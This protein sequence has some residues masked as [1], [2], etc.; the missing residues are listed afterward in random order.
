MDLSEEYLKK[1]LT[2]SIKGSMELLGTRFEEKNPDRPKAIT[3]VRDEEHSPWDGISYISDIH[4]D[5]KIG[6]LFKD[7]IRYDKVEEY[8]MDIASFLMLSN[9]FK[10]ILIA[11]DTSYNFLVN[12]MFY[13]ALSQ[14]RKDEKIIVVLGNHELWGVGI[15]VP[16]GLDRREY[17]V[18]EYRK[19]CK[20]YGLILLENDVL[21]LGKQFKRILTE[22]EFLAISDDEIR[23]LMSKAGHVILGG[24][25]FAGK[26][27][28]NNA[29]TGLYGNTLEDSEKEI[30][31]SKRFLTLYDKL[32]AYSGRIPITA[33]S[34]MPT[35]DWCEGI[36]D[37][38]IIHVN[39]HTHHNKRIV[40]DSLTLYA[41]NQI[42]YA[43]N[44]IY[45]KYYFTT[46]ISEPF[47]FAEDGIY[48]ITNRQYSIFCDT[49]PSAT[50]CER[51][52][53]II[54]LK[55]NGYYMFMNRSSIGL[56]ILDG[57]NLVGL[58]NKDPEYYYERMME[59]VEAVDEVYSKIREKL[60]AIAEAVRS[61]GGEG[62]V[63]G[64]IVDISYYSHLYYNVLDGTITPY[65]A[66][67]IVN[68]TVYQ[69]VSSLLYYEEKSIYNKMM[70]A[71]QSGTELPAIYTGGQIVSKGVEYKGTEM[72]RLS[73][74]IRCY[75]H[76]KEEKVIRTWDDR[77][78]PDKK[79]IGNP[80]RES[81]ENI[82]SLGKNESEA[83]QREIIR[84][85][86]E[87]TM[88]FIKS[89]QD[90]MSEFGI[91]KDMDRRLRPKDYR[92]KIP[93]MMSKL[94]LTKKMRLNSDM[95]TEIIR[96]VVEEKTRRLRR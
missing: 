7:K 10:T 83:I 49:L 8:V 20:R 56:S 93:P 64:S 2:R 66:W 4:L 76:L 39:G 36:P 5:H 33:L 59:Y 71:I 92:E 35:E 63:H 28:V 73:R 30:A 45:F 61:I 72:Y 53:N 52:L 89:N 80:Q 26:D 81:Q 15:D 11:G 13:R 19:L 43:N 3:Y 68:K 84:L 24:T 47:R 22:E 46:F 95:K 79:L 77:I 65:F 18:N 91:Y 86:A 38:G 78:L 85:F 75:Q 94:Y 90:V 55:R 67:D 14:C 21:F 1:H 6:K 34:H 48:R 31:L 70:K 50:K 25:G 32:R 96:D 51:N 44:K 60:D 17:I 40:S 9:N 62:T 74:R 58:E 12:Q 42:G 27:P 88:D 29:Q 23:D 37:P 16:K 54:M 41:D 69:N 57:G 87:R 82:V